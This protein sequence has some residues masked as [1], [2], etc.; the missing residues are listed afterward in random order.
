MTESAETR[1]FC[2]SYELCTDSQERDDP[3][4]MN[5]APSP[6]DNKAFSSGVDTM[7]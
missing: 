3:G 2:G 7:R 6:M 4:D 5:I 1:A